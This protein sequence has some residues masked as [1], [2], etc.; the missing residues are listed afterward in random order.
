MSVS[1]IKT[2][3]V[4][5]TYQQQRDELAA[6]FRW[7]VRLNMHEAVANHFSVAVNDDGSQFLMN[8]NQRHFSLIRSS[9]LLLLDSNNQD[10][11][12]QDNA[13]DPTA[14]FL[15]GALHRHCPH[16]RCALHV[17]S[18]YSTVLACLEDS[19]LLPID[20]NTAMFY[21]RYVIDKEFAGLAFELE[22]ERC[23]KLFIDPDVKVMI[24][25]NHGL[26]VIGSSVADA[27][28]QLYYFER[29]AETYVKALWT[30]KPLKVLPHEV[31]MK[32]ARQLSHYPGQVE[33]HFADIMEILDNEEPSY[34]D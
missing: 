15:H 7:A 17:H 20:Q 34:R 14:W 26:M 23:A 4:D 19:H 13:P 18:V 28:N 22:G 25:G 10:T 30:N 21:N 12:R 27:F 5:Q 31:A 8:P 16:A 6:A 9:D 24:M 1:T 11:M 3:T 32:T 29:A 33:R 2:T